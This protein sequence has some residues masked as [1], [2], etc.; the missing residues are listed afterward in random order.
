VVNRRMDVLVIDD[1]DLMCEVVERSLRRIGAGY[2][3]VSAIDGQDG[4]DILRGRSETK[5]SQPYLVLLDLNMPRMDGF[6]F[7]EEVRKD[8][9]LWQSV[10]FVLTTSNADGDRTRAYD[11][12]IAGYMVKSAVGPQLAHLATM[13]RDYASV[14]EL[15]I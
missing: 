2:R 5:V 11:E 3:V 12:Q 9:K 6:E 10:I 7:L 1:D 13:L 4:L 15:P 8:P 14:V